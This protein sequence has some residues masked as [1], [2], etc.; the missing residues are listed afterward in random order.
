MAN[1]AFRDD[2]RLSG[3]WRLLEAAFPHVAVE[4]RAICAKCGRMPSAAVQERMHR[5]F[6]HQVW[7]NRTFGTVAKVEAW[8]GGAKGHW[9]LSAPWQCGS[10]PVALLENKAA[11]VGPL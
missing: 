5:A 9:L 1:A 3:K 8:A 11:T 10:G 2:N 4:W 7:T 6:H